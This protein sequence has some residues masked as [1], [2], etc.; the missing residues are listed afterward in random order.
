MLA[1]MCLLVVTSG[2]AAEGQEAT[3][4]PVEATPARP[5]NNPLGL[6]A[7]VA[8]RSRDPLGFALAVQRGGEVHVYDALSPA[9]ADPDEDEEAAPTARQL[10]AVVDAAPFVRAP[11][12]TLDH[13][14]T[15]AAGRDPDIAPAAM[16]SAATIARALTF[17]ALQRR[18]VDPESLTPARD[19]FAELAADESARGD[20]RGLAAATA[21]SLL[22]LQADP[23]AAAE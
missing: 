8:V 12:R 23:E 3:P 2:R 4:Q 21:E 14:A 18:E 1:L 9:G 15:L 5:A 20:L 11:E 10:L 13:L 7:L 22:H 16:M 17:H 6:D 19:R